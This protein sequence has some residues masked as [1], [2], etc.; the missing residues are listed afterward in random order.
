MA[1]YLR[2]N[3]DVRQNPSR[4]FIRLFLSVF[5]ACL[6]TGI[7]IRKVGLSQIARDQGIFLYSADQILKGGMPYLD[8]WDHKGPMTYLINALWILIGGSVGRAA[9]AEAV[10]LAFSM[11]L[12]FFV[13]LKK[14]TRWSLFL[15]SLFGLTYFLSKF[16]ESWGLT[17]TITMPLVFF[18]GLVLVIYAKGNIDQANSIDR[19]GPLLLGSIFCALVLVRPNN[20]IGFFIFSVG[21][22]LIVGKSK[23]QALFRYSLGFFLL[24]APVFFWIQINGAAPAFWEQFIRYNYYYSKSG[25]F[26]ERLESI[27]STH[28]FLLFIGFI[29]LYFLLFPK[30]DKKSRLL[31]LLSFSSI[32]I[33]V[34]M[35]STSG[36]GYPHYFVVP[37]TTAFLTFFVSLALLPSRNTKYLNVISPIIILS[38]FI[39]QLIRVPAAL[40]INEYFKTAE[41]I[42]KNTKPQDL[43][44]F[45]GAETGLLALANRTSASSITYVYPVTSQ[46]YPNASNTQKQ[47]LSDLTSNA[48][49]I[50][51]T[52]T[53][54]K[55]ELDEIVCQETSRLY[56]ENQA[57]LVRQFIRE[58]YI[59]IREIDGFRVFFSR[60]D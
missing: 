54:L 39:S 27:K 51:I 52:R 9:V 13:V 30:Q 10:F 43:I 23:V 12:F 6:V 53:N 16:H 3:Y 56:S 34:L 1:V 60:R 33:D 31:I 18:G 14:N 38:I 11:F 36:R 7:M 8:S 24:L 57:F 21:V 44:Y 26:H 58:N 28:S 49:K 15:I 45:Y 4:F 17:E 48:P 32:Y 50:I 29:T 22:L 35:T 40:N 59:P 46:F 42:S 55:C 2:Y 41:F 25:S 47:L 20:G 5:S 37:V 19:I